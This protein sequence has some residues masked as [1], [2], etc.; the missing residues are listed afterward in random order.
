MLARELACRREL[1]PQYFRRLDLT[2]GGLSPVGVRGGTP[3]V[4]ITSCK[5]RSTGRASRFADRH[6]PQFFV[7]FSS[8]SRPLSGAKLIRELTADGKQYADACERKRNL[9]IRQSAG[10]ECRGRL[11]ILP[12]SPRGSSATSFSSF[13]PTPFPHSSVGH[14]R[15]R[16]LPIDAARRLSFH[17]PL[18]PIARPSG[19]LEIQLG[20]HSNRAGRQNSKNL[21]VRPCFQRK[22]RKI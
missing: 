12:N 18:R 8:A 6:A 5:Q 9:V 11:V 20:G 21:T 3:G 14:A 17:P 22:I 1:V 2:N 10:A 4:G 7:A 16:L 19:Q 15:D 13:A